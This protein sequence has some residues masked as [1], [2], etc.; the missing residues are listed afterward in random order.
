[1]YKTKKF[2]SQSKV[3]VFKFLLDNFN[4]SINEAQKWI[5]KK[6]VLID[7]KPVVKKSQSFKGEIEIILFQTRSKD[8]KPLFQT[9]DF[10]LYDKPSGV[11]VHPKDRS[12]EYSI[13][14][15][16]KHSFGKEANITH[17]LD[18]ETSGLILCSKNKIVER[19]LKELFENQ[20]IQKSY[21]ALV[22]GELKEPILVDKPIA[23]NSNFDEI[24]L[25]VYVNSEGKESSTFIKPLYYNNKTDQ[26][27]V[28]VTPKTGRQHQIRVHLHHIG[29]PIVGD[30]LYGRSFRDAEDYL[31]GK[32]SRDKRIELTGAYRL[33]LHSQS[34]EFFYK[35]RF[36]IVSKMRLFDLR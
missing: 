5:D 7:G 21:L 28:E 2:F 9:R 3:K 34:L 13:T 14:H 8:L 18:K 22:W 35:N 24:K 29:H 30:P 1:L 4:I 23:K 27:L 15:E 33:M 32:L 17:R 20:Q 6:R 16:V 11:L 19:E 25:M 26:T 31:E 12:T 10:L 36:K